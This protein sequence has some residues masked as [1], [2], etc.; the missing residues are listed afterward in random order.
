MMSAFAM[1]QAFI[2]APNMILAGALSFR[3]F[4]HI[5]SVFLQSWEAQSL[6]LGGVSFQLRFETRAAAADV[7]QMK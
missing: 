4:P 2:I 1:P 3:H 6:P 5:E 7:M